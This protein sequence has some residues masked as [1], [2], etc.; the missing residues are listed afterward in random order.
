MGRAPF[1]ITSMTPPDATTDALAAARVL[2]IGVGGLG[3]PAATALAEAGV[4]TIGLVDPDVVE[5]S[6]LPRQT[7]YDDG[8]VG[9]PKV[10]AAAA[11][12][13]ASH[14]ALRLEPVRRRLGAA[15]AG[16]LRGWDVVLDGTDTVAAKFDVNDAAVAAGVPLVHAGAIGFRAQL[17]TVL[18]GRATACYRCLFEEAPPPEDA[19]SCDEAGVLG[20]AV[21]LAGT[22]QAAEALRLLAGAAPLFADRLLTLDCRD[23]AWR[24]VPL[25]RREDCA[26]CGSGT[27]PEPHPRSCRP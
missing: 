8:D 16:L 5:P 18:P 26:T 2:V 12:R 13:A 7:L 3:C 1:S 19:P 15:D 9:R 14:P 17:M 25:A 6:N 4:G 23:G 10:A 27:R 20:P 11:R 21:H 22:L 24:T